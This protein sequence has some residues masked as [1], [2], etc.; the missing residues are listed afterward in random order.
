MEAKGPEWRRLVQGGGHLPGFG[1]LH[2][3]RE[4]AAKPE[5]S[6]DNRQWEKA[7]VK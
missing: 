4:V 3:G 2:G 6:L 5:E 7:A 1:S